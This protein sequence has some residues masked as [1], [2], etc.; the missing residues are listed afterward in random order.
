MHATDILKKS[1]LHIYGMVMSN[2]MS[3]RGRILFKLYRLV[4]CVCTILTMRLGR[5]WTKMYTRAIASH[6]L[7]A[8]PMNLNILWN[9]L[10]NGDH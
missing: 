1:N 5:G 6:A 9:L 2:S 8:G 3:W 7:N 4:S 10:E